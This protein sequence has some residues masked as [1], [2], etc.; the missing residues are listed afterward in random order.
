VARLHWHTIISSHLG[1][2]GFLIPL[3]VIVILKGP[4]AAGPSAWAAPAAFAYLAL[5]GVQLQ[6]NQFGLDGPGVK[7]LLLLPLDSRELLAGKAL[8]LAGYMGA[9]TLLLMAIMLFSGSLTPARMLPALALSAC[10]FLAQIS[11]GHW[12]SAWLPRPMPRDSLRNSNMAGAVIW[13]GMAAS[14]AGAFFFGGLWLLLAWQAPLL[15]APVMV[16]L[17]AGL[18][19]TYRRLVL[20]AAAAYLDRRREVLVQALG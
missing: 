13:L 19:L 4:A 5:S 10:L 18:F 11:L 1:K 17:A 14:V 15:L 6:L 2:A 12:T 8:A 3:M 9:Q 7:A 20:P 16:L